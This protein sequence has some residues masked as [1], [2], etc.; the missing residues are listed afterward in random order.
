MGRVVPFHRDNDHQDS[1]CCDDDNNV[2]DDDFAKEN[3]C[4]LG[5]GFMAHA[6][7][8]GTVPSVTYVPLK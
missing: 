8:L 5:I 6:D 4:Y 1:D 2:G 3:L 7:P